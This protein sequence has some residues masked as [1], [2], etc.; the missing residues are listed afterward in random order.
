MPKDNID[1]EIVISVKNLKRDF[2]VGQNTIKALRDINLEIDST[3]FAVI[4]GPSGCGKS[5]LLNI[6]L[7]IDEPTSGEVKVRT[8]NLFSLSE[9]ERAS[10]RARKIGMI[11]QMPYWVKSLNVLENIALPL[12]IRGL[13]SKSA[14]ARAC[15]TME[16]IGIGDLTKQIPTQLSGGQQQKASFARAIATNPWIIMADEPTGNLDSKSS[17]E[18][19]KLMADLNHQQ[20]RTIILVTHNEQYWNAGNRRIEM[21]DGEIIKDTKHKDG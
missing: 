11:H 5:T 17:D 15:E 21:K 6:I 1:H 8:T 20:K 7:G 13:D 3:D 16:D 19:M 14:T 9:D 2:K 12:V 4:F 18:I 10:F